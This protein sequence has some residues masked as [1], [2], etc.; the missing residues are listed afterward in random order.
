MASGLSGREVQRRSTG[1]SVSPTRRRGLPA[2]WRASGG[3]TAVEMAFLLPV[4]L[5]FVF[6]IIEFARVVLTQ[7]ALQFAAEAAARC[8][9]VSPSSCTA[10]GGSS[11]DIPA[12]AASQTMGVSIPSSAFTYTQNANATANCTTSQNI[13]TGGAMVKASYVF[14]SIAT[15]LVPLNVTLSACSYHP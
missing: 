8:A 12:Y 13:G 15:Q 2:L 1:C 7:T 4:F 3:A 10:P 6:G 11:M 14:D 9:A 5:L